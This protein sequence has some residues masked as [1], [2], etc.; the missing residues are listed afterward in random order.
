MQFSYELQQLL[1][2]STSMALI[3][4]YCC[5]V[6][7]SGTSLRRI[8]GNVYR[9]ESRKC[10][11]ARASS[12]PF[13]SRC[14]PSSDCVSADVC[15]WRTSELCVFQFASDIAVCIDDYFSFLCEVFMFDCLR[16]HDHFYIFAMYFLLYNGSFTDS[17]WSLSAVD[18]Y[19]VAF[20]TVLA[21]VAIAS[22]MLDLMSR[23]KLYIG[24][25][26]IRLILM[27]HI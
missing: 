10:F 14:S 20:M 6:W 7:W 8:H 9:N 13:A 18:L 21:D 19:C 2:F 24:L 23:L 15:V 25:S 16:G 17:C 26:A 4:C 11:T 1:L 3:T 5:L 27:F 12:T 22:R